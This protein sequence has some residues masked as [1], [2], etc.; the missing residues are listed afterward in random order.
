MMTKY[1]SNG[2]NSF[3]CEAVTTIK[4]RRSVEYFDR[5]KELLALGYTVKCLGRRKATLVR[6]DS[7]VYDK[8]MIYTKGW[9]EA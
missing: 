1:I 2:R 6:F 3:Y 7:N 5:L 8:I 4:A 9:K